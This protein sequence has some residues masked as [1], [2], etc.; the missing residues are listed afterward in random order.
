MN[1]QQ[2]QI[3]GSSAVSIIF[4]SIGTKQGIPSFIYNNTNHTRT[5]THTYIKRQSK[6]I[7]IIQEINRTYGKRDT[8]RI[9]DKRICF[10]AIPR[11]HQIK[12]DK[13]KDY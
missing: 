2:D 3:F 8:N 5:H 4:P 6:V 1:K 11:P 10:F 7:I 9:T 12:V 13:V